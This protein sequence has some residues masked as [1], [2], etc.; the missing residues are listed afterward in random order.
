LANYDRQFVKDFAK[1]ARPLHEI[2]RKEIKWEWGEKQHNVF[3]E[4][5]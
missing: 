5:K 3:E 1:I 2:T 4:L